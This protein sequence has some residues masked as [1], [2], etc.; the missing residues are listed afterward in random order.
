MV[1][2]N[3]FGEV[4]STIQAPALAV[5]PD[6]C[7]RLRHRLSKCTRCADRCPTKAIEWGERTLSIDPDKC[8]SCG[9][10]TSVCPNG[11]FEALK[12]HNT[13]ILGRVKELLHQ[14]KEIVFECNPQRVDREADTIL[15]P[16]L[17]RI[18]E[19]VLIG[20]IALGARAVFLTPSECQGCQNESGLSVIQETVNNCNQL[21]GSMGLSEPISFRERV[22][23]AEELKRT[24]RREFLA[25]ITQEA[26]KLGA[27]VA[28]NMIDNLQKK[29]PQESKKGSLPVCLPEKR[30]LLLTAMSK[31]KKPAD[32]VNRVIESP[33]FCQFGVK[34]G[35]TVCQMCAFFCPTGAL[36]KIDENG[37]FG[38]RFKVSFCTNCGL[39]QDICYKQVVQLSNQVSLTKVL[40]QSSEVVLMR[41]RPVSLPWEQQG[42]VRSEFAQSLAR[43]L[44]E[45]KLKGKS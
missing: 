34:E 24:S 5:H 1:S 38:L 16:C 25:S 30:E 31:L 10:C 15:V 9:I 4:L 14:N 29:I 19:G 20:C 17:G 43:S 8:T 21:L 7:S 12:P 13:E 44:L 45:E 40:S 11:V 42:S 35:C 28:S 39:C 27:E 33:L 32:G 6:Y 3:Q 36:S 26:K 22:K 41:E 2:I 18:D 23:T 37:Q